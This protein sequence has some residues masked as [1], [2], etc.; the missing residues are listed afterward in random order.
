[1]TRKASGEHCWQLCV[2]E[3]RMFSPT[4]KNVSLEYSSWERMT[5]PKSSYKANQEHLPLLPFNPRVTVSAVGRQWC[6]NFF[7]PEFIQS[8]S[9]LYN[10][11]VRINRQL[12]WVRCSKRK[13]DLYLSPSLQQCYYWW[14]CFP[15]L[16]TQDKL[17]RAIKHSSSLAR[18]KII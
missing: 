10:K 3:P 9:L 1:M 13:H 11:A 16:A 6:H 14:N 2:T 5:A 8:L 15:S 4:K 17:L 12:W 18:R 7:S